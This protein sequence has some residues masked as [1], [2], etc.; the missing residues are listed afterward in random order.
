MNCFANKMTISVVSSRKFSRKDRWNF[1]GCIQ[2]I[3]LFACRVPTHQIP[4]CRVGLG[5]R[6]QLSLDWH[7]FDT[8]TKGG[9]GDG[10]PRQSFRLRLRAPFPP[11]LHVRIM[12]W[13]LRNP[14]CNAPS[15]ACQGKCCTYGQKEALPMGL[16]IIAYM[17]FD[18]REKIQTEDLKK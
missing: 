16:S 15:G 5:F 12:S 4:S 8:A 1:N 17:T 2:W 11:S 3:A 9:G 7:N 14:Q 18:G 6:S 13:P 10:N